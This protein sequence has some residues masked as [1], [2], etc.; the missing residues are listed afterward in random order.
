MDELTV[1]IEKGIPIG[2]GPQNSKW[3]FLSDMQVDDC[4]TV[5][6]NYTDAEIG[7]AYRSSRHLAHPYKGRYANV[8]YFTH[9]HK[10]CGTDR[11]CERE[12]VASSG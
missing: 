1:K 7:G 10:Y 4:A 5:P 9:T 8:P 2:S 3:A 6:A 11:V 12:D